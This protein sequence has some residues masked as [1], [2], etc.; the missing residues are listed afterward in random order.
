[1]GVNIFQRQLTR[2]RRVTLTP[3]EQN[4][5]NIIHQSIGGFIDPWQQYRYASIIA[6][7]RQLCPDLESKQANKEQVAALKLR[8]PAAIVSGI[9]DGSSEGTMQQ[10]NGVI[11]IDIDAADNPSIYDWEAVKS[12]ISQSKFVAYCGLSVTALGIFLLIPVEDAEEH[13]AHFDAIRDDLEHTIFTI[14]QKGEE[15]P[16]ILHGLNVDGAPRNICAKRFVSYDPAPYINADAEVYTKKKPTP[17]LF[18]P[19]ITRRAMPG[20]PF[21][22]E[23]FLQEHNIP[24]NVRER[25][26][27]L[28]YEIQC[29]WHDQHTTKGGRRATAV[30]VDANGRPGFNCKHGHC[31]G[32]RWQHFRAFYDGRYLERQQHGSMATIKMPDFSNV[33]WP[34]VAPPKQEQQQAAPLQPPSE[35]MAEGY[36]NGIDIALLFTENK[37]TCPF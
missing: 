8:L 25:H 31:E 28:Q 9:A 33:Q 24:Y 17:T 1:M 27:G 35:Q 34:T 14:Q 30:Y 32:K 12:V 26:G 5:N 16:T 4:G 7:I 29:P 37:E 36:I 23:A 19:K 21:N 20:E 3:E 11:C 6:E 13:T 2:L 22:V 10:R 15:E 18:I